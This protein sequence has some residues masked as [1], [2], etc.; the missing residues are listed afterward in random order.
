MNILQISY[1]WPNVIYANSGI[2]IK[3]T[4][5][6]LLQYNSAQNIHLLSV[7]KAVNKEYLKEKNFTLKNYWNFLSKNNYFHSIQGLSH[8]CM[9]F[10]PILGV[11]KAIGYNANLAWG[12][13]KS[14]ILRYVKQNN[15]SLCHAH[16][17]NPDGHIAYKIKQKTGVPYIMHL[18][19]ADVQ[20]YHNRT[21]REQEIIN[22]VYK[23]ADL[24]ICNSSK[25]E[26]L[27]HSIINKNI[28]SKIIAFGI[29]IS[30]TNQKRKNFNEPITILSVG[31]LIEI[32]GIQYALE[33]LSKL[34]SEFSFNYHIIGSGPMEEKLKD[35]A[36]KNQ[37]EK[38]V[39]FHGRQSHEYV[40]KKMEEAEIFVLPSYNEAFGVVYLEALSNAC[41]V[42]GIQGQG[43][44][45]IH[46]KK[47]CIYMA[48]A[49]DTDSLASAIKDVIL[50]K[51][52]RERYIANG[53][54]VAR[55]DYEWKTIA[56]QYNSTFNEVLETNS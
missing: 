47:E 16:F 56:N 27:L 17:S 18:H 3:K 51:E 44:E 30:D 11:S 38:C 6:K 2:F 26:R 34:K 24:V 41:A 31:N 28:P 20:E 12:L 10:P 50:D 54:D 4:V 5:E 9:L 48:N 46:A 22:L 52:K 42:I 15:I 45:D 13:N 36:S 1:Q 35:I 25:S 39:T 23:N 43:C 37:L 53:L 14:R 8:K 49:Q 29:D 55:N 32:K 21:K 40:L 19:G 33:A 7:N